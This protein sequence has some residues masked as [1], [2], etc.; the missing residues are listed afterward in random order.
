VVIEG[1][2]YDTS[3]KKMVLGKRYRGEPDLDRLI[4]HRLSDES[5]SSSPANRGSP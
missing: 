5:S 4:A 1:R 3:D 2:V